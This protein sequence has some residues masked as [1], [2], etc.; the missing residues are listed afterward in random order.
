MYR[1]HTCW[2]SSKLI[3]RYS[4]G[5]LGDKASND[6]AVMENVDFQGFRTL[7]FRQL[8]KGGQRYYI[9][10]FSPLSPFHWLQ[11]T[12]PWMTLNHFTLNF[13]YYK[14]PFYIFTVETVDTR[15]QRWCADVRKRTVIRRILW[16]REKLRIF[17]RRYV[18]GTLTDKA[19][20]SI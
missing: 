4:R 18:F 1:G 5:F 8:R 14:Q 15:D 3:T 16:I 7:R 17:R 19:N 10:L 6:S 20:I 12:W 9:V 13:Y 2:V 11:N